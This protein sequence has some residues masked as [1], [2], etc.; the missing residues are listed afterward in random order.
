MAAQGVL[1]IAVATH[2]ISGT[3][4]AMQAARAAANAPGQGIN[5]VINLLAKIVGGSESARVYVAAD[6]GGGTAG[7]F[8]VAVT[9]ANYTAGE[10][11]VICGVTFTIVAAYSS[12]LGIARNQ[13]VAQGSDTLSG[14]EVAKKINAHPLLK[15]AW[16]AVNVAGTVTCT[17]KDKG[18]HANLAVV[19]E[20]GDAFVVTQV[21]NGAEGTLS[22]PLKAWA[23]GI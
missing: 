21:S 19:A 17:M 3:D 12:D 23:K 13:L 20:T 16:T 9:D 10:T 14:A 8:T 11:L 7:T 1:Y 15:D 6:S 4:L 5:E 2:N 18:L 22:M